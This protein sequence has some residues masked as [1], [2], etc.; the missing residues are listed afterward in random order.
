M[1]GHLDSTMSFSQPTPFVDDRSTLLEDGLDD[2]EFAKYQEHKG[3]MKRPR[4]GSN[5]LANRRMSTI[6]EK[7][8]SLCQSV[9]S[10][11]AVDYMATAYSLL[12]RVETDYDEIR[13]IVTGGEIDGWY[14]ASLPPL[15]LGTASYLGPP[16]AP[17]IPATG[18]DVVHQIIVP[19]SAGEAP[20]CTAHNGAAEAVH[21][22][23]APFVDVH[24]AAVATGQLP[25][26]STAAPAMNILA[27]EPAV[28][29][30]TGDSSRDGMA[31]TT[32]MLRNIPAGISRTNV[33][34]VLRSAGL[35]H[36]VDFIYVPMNLKGSGNFGYAFVCFDCP[37]V[38]EQFKEKMQDYAGWGEPSGICLKVEWSETQGLEALVERYRNSPIMHR[39]IEDEIKPAMF[40]NG[41]RVAFPRPTKPVRAPRLRRKDAENAK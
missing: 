27:T 24:A 7:A 41:T 15:Y 32:V 39:S 10:P 37:S 17:A 38:A 33:L 30:K 14:L 20:A 23:E 5:L 22:S 35:A 2:M 26:Q 9:L 29:A 31:R 3:L 16:L 36:H 12:H 11:C 1:F 13:K 8:F 40:K 25:S 6:V 4:A 34:D 28:E 18:L 21:I 19:S